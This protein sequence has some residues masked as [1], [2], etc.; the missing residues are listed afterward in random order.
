MF[1]FKILKVTYISIPYFCVRNIFIHLL[2]REEKRRNISDLL[3]YIN[4]N[5]PIFV[6]HKV[7]SN[8]N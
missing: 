3:K 5:D 6:I 2:K 1:D 8:D 4:K 7:Y